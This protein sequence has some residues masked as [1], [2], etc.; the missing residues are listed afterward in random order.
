[1]Q[2]YYVKPGGN[3]WV[4]RDDTDHIVGFV[5]LKRVSENVG[6]LKRMAIIKEYRRR[7]IGQRLGETLID[8]AKDH[9]FEAIE[10]G[11]S[12][13]EEAHD[14]YLKLGFVDIGFGKG[15]ADYQ[16]QLDLTK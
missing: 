6:A 11:T 12:V 1:M 8:W 15:G 13:T 10:L 14:L 4:A 3:F 16:M 7:G 2:D 5:G 9:D